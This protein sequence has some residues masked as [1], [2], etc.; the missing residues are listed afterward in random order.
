MKFDMWQF[1]FPLTMARL[2][3]SKKDRA[4]SVAIMLEKAINEIIL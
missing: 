2:T 1:I 4:E 3:G